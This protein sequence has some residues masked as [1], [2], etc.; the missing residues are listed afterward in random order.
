MGRTRS[1]W[2][3]DARR[4]RVRNERGRLY[5]VEVLFPDTTSSLSSMLCICRRSG[6]WYHRRSPA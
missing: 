6:V 2:L 4:E 3:R 1:Y 5:W